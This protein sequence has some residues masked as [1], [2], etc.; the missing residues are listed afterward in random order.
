M[1]HKYLF[2]IILIC[3]FALIGCEKQTHT[4]RYEIE[5]SVPTIAVHY[6]NGTN[7]N[8]S[9]DL[10]PGWST[11]FTVESYYHLHLRVNT[12]NSDGTATCRIYVDG[13]LAAEATASGKFK[14][15]SCSEFPIPP[16]P[17]ESS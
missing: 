4:V 12:K 7:G 1:N 10:A 2:S 6:K 17:E 15:A 11:E 5:G 16:Q 3:A 13:K 9:A 8:E 14:H